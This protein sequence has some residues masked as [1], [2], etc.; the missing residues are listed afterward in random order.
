ML[1]NLKKIFNS[2]EEE[3]QEVVIKPVTR[4][5]HVDPKVGKYVALTFDDG[6]CSKDFAG[7]GKGVT[8][9]ILDILKEYDVKATFNIIGSTSENRPDGQGEPGDVDWFG[10]KYDHFPCVGK[11]SLGGAV[12]HPEI[13][14]RMIEEGHELSNHGYRHIPYGKLSGKLSKRE[15]FRNSADALDDLQ[16]LHVFIEHRFGY[17]MRLAKAPHGAEYFEDGKTVDDVYK[18]M[19][20]K[21]IGASYKADSMS[22]KENYQADVESAVLPMVKILET[23]PD[24]FC[25]KIIAFRDGC[26]ASMRTPILDSLPKQ[27]ELLKKYGYAFVTISDL[28][29]LRPKDSVETALKDAGIEL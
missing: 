27:I 18:N 24:A 28:L 9:C 13:V 10:T 14:K 1:I 22:S 19:G 21:Y 12:N 17:K 8:E 7:R 16:R 26:N 3:T 29:I 15:F 5:D 2:K 4:I 23:N 11:D 6:P 20:Y 25:G